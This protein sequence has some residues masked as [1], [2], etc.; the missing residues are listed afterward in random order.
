M[1][2]VV[3]R[4]TNTQNP[5]SHPR[6]LACTATTLWQPQIFQFQFQ[7]ILHLFDP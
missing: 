7:F 5:T 3:Q 4:G 1:N 2:E 6:T